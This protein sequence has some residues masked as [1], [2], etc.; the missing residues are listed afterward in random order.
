MADFI[1]ELKD[2]RI[3]PAVGMYVAS[4]WVLIEIL[5]RLVERYLL[6]PY[7]TDI[8]FWGLYSLIPAVMIISWTHG[9][10]GKDKAGRLEKIGVPINLIASLGLLFTV[11][12]DK[13]LSMAA[14]QIT[15]SNELGQQETHYIPSDTFRRRMVVFFWENESNKPELDW[16]QYGITELLVQDL[17]QDPFVLASSPWSNF[18]NGFFPRIKQA[19]FADGLGVPRSLMREIADEANRQYFV[20]GSLHQEADEF[21]ITARIW[22][23]Q[24]A[25]KLVELSRHSWDI[26]AAVDA[27]S[28]DIREELGV[29]KSSGRIAEDLPLTETYG[30]SEDA[31]KAYIQGLNARLFENDFDASNAFFDQAI[32]IDPNFVLAWFVK[33]QNLIQAGDLPAAQSALSKAQ[34]LDYRL[35][36]R[37]R[38][39]LKASLYRLSGQHEKMMAFLRLQAQVRNDATAH[40]TLATMLMMSGELEEAKSESLLAL[41]R[42][43]LNV[44]IYL[45]MSTLERATGDMTAAVEYA[46]QYQEKR[47]EDI[48]AHV[49]LGDLLRDSGNLQA[50]AEQYEQAQI[51][52]ND[53]VQPTLKLSDIAAR[54]GDINT[55]R[56]LLSEAESYA[57]TPADK[58]L[59]RQSAALL[60]SRLGKIHEV[61][62][63]TLAQE[64]FLSQSQG[65]LQVALGVYSPLASYYV[66]VDDPVAAR[67]A[68]ATAKSKLQPPL[69]KFLAFSEALILVNEGNIEAAQAAV[70]Q[71]QEVIDQFQI[72]VLEFQGHVLRARIAEARGDF[73]AVE[74]HY[75]AA[76]DNMEHS[77]FAADLS[78]AVPQTYAEIAIAQ[79]KTGQLD[80]ARH[81]IETGSRVD[82]S[83]PLLWVAKAHLQRAQEMPQLALASLGFALAI[84]KEADAGYVYAEEAMELAEK[85]QAV[86]L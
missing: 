76:L 45:R 56:K 39:Q 82:P 13:D 24:T 67:K 42:D 41:E 66:Q 80:A 9:K 43:A 21:L 5:D 57:R 16:L 48:D 71:G 61:I 17:Q 26:H 18:G 32:S 33:A 8:V 52:E 19:G 25:R 70:E 20:E 12:G 58:V 77:V 15:V 59:V 29:P 35:P 31:L 23:T 69:D 75:R 73:A 49:Q 72:K 11:F 65:P 53:P 28:R 55:A 7:L 6:S 2:R 60:E 47:P 36:S 84:W 74:R 37:D 54:Q 62:R 30:E 34:E 64:E 51:L 83:E 14:T 86:S 50:A 81:S 40:N 38:Y 79:I 78:V 85:L 10:K 46:R 68:L 1:T 4:T 44:G 3:L 22:D 63:Q 27:L